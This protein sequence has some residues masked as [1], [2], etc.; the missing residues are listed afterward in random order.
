MDPAR[1]VELKDLSGGTKYRII[2]IILLHGEKSLNHLERTVGDRVYTTWPI[3]PFNS[4]DVDAINTGRI[5]CIM[6]CRGHH[7][8]NV[9]I[10]ILDKEDVSA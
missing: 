4:E 10:I 6:T 3:F 2:S 8:S 1:L 5:R 7:H 9:L